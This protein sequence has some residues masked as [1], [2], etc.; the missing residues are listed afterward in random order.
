[1]KKSEQYKQIILQTSEWFD[2]SKKQLQ[3]LIDKKNDSKI[4]FEGKEGDKVELP[5]ELKKGFFFGIQTAIEVLGEFPVKIT[6]TDDSDDE[7]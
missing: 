2:K 3:L 1:M 5:E 6:K 7:N 4:F